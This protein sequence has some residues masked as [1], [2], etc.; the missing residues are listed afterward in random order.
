MVNGIDKIK[1]LSCKVTKKEI[2][3]SRDGQ[4]LVNNC[5][6]HFFKKQKKQEEPSEAS[7]N[8]FDLVS[9]GLNLYAEESQMSLASPTLT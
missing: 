4:I 9:E 2:L 8:Q 7:A 6:Q 3:K 1:V 5:G